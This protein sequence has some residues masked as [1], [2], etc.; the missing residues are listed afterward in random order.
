MGIGVDHR[1]ATERLVRYWDPSAIIPQILYEP[2]SRAVMEEVARDRAIVTWWASR[3]ECASAVARQS[4]EG[5]LTTAGSDTSRLRLRLL[6]QGW[7]EIGPTED[8][9]LTAMRLIR[10]HPLRT[11]DALQLAAAITASESR[12]ASLV[13]V[14][15]DDR[16]AE[17]ADKEGF[18]VLRP[19]AS[20]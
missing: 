5:R 14:T 13:F 8:V 10:T 19:G 17:A 1:G 15:L 9:R 12:P 11:G 7:Q 18:P 2:A 3:I 4:R 20:V 16:L 6:H